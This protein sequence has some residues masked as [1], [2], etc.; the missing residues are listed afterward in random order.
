M[1]CPADILG[2]QGHIAARLA[3]YEHREQQLRMADAVSKALS[4]GRHLVV[5]AGTGVGKSFG[6]L[7]PAIQQVTSERA[8][9]NKSGET[10]PIVVST[11]TISLQEQLINKD[12][13]FLRSVMPNEFTAVLMKGRGNYISRR[14]LGIAS[15]RSTYLFEAEREFQDLAKIQSW[16]KTTSDG[17][18]SDL[19]SR[20]SGMVWDE[21][22]SDSGNCLGRKCPQYHD[23]FYFASRRRAQNA[24]ILVV[25]HAL[26]FADLSLRRQN[27]SILPD[28]DAVILDEAHSLESV[29]ADHLGL[30]ITSGQLAYVLNKLYNGRN[31]RGLLVAK[32]LRTLQIQTGRCT[33][34]AE[35]FFRSVTELVAGL[36]HRNGRVHR[37]LD[38][39]NRVSPA[40]SALAEELK[41]YAESLK[42]ESDRLD[43][44]SAQDRLSGLATEIAAWCDQSLPDAVYW[45]ESTET[46]YGQL[47]VTLSAA[48]VNVGPILA[49]HL[50][51]RVRC[52]VMTS[53]TLSVGRQPSFDYY[54]SRIGLARS[55][56]ERL[57]SPFDYPKQAKLIL[58]DG[59]SDPSTEKDAYERQIVGLIQRYVARTHGHAFVLF[60]SYDLLRRTVAAM[61]PWLTKNNLACYSQADGTPRGQLLDRFKTDSSGVLFG[62]DS[63]WQGVD[64]PGD[65][66]QNVIITK[67]PFSVPDQ[68][69]LEARLESIRASGGN[70]FNDYQLPEAIIK[71][72]QGFGRL[73][74]TATDRG[75]VVIL[76]PRIRTKRYGQLFL[77]S[78]PHCQVVVESAHPTPGTDRL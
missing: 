69:L 75:I 20:P 67:L 25:N 72:K 51:G 24:Q 10:K 60:T 58:L 73:I 16:V 30:G 35:E 44:V 3:R 42:N 14:R 63:F 6:Y 39:A 43:F 13:P 64:V 19:S 9:R 49:E 47:R 38:L 22:A 17:S 27:A 37:P 65:A 34:I 12:L 74:R 71:L 2:P 62:T 57:G 70:P 32:D 68:P 77:D 56:S 54:K 29:A 55:D 50:F 31:G 52:V 78:L 53:A 4:A 48:P 11:H 66:L 26:F 5:E 33:E 76:D 36:P 18:L 1:T 23:C 41:R 46:R 7:V 8:E 59:M 45:V 28:Y 61:L 15:A 21:V 40:L